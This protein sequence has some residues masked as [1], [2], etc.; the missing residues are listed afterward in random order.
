MLEFQ[1]YDTTKV[2]MAQS[3]KF[4]LKDSDSFV[5]LIEEEGRK[6]GRFQYE[7]Y[8]EEGGPYAKVF[9]RTSLQFLYNIIQACIDENDAAIIMCCIDEDSSFD[10]PYTYADIITTYKIDAVHLADTAKDI[11]KAYLVNPDWRTIF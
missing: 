8:F 2:T 10:F 3:N 7:I 9:G 5:Q 6:R 1:Q 4:K 11:A